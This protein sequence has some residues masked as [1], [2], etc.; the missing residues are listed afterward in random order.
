VGLDDIRTFVIAARRGSLSGAARD[1][2]VPKSTVSR[3]IARLEDELGQELI[4]R[5]SRTFRMTEAGEALFA[6]SAPAIHDLDEATAIVRGAGPEPAGD[7]RITAPVD[8]GSSPAFVRFCV[9]FRDAYPKIKLT[10]DLTDRYVDVVAEGYDLA[11][12]IHARPLES[13]TTLKARK[14]GPLAIGIYASPAYL[15]RRG[16]PTH[17]SELLDHDVIG[18][19]RPEG[20]ER[21]L[22][23]R[24]DE[25][26][27]WFEVRPSLLTSSMPFLPS[28]VEAGAGLGLVADLVMAPL[29]DAGT[30]ERVLPEWEVPP[31]T[32]SLVWPASRVEVP[33]L[34]ALLDFIAADFPKC[35]SEP[36][37]PR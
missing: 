20:G 14:L 9:A 23:R 6:R 19:V 17:P 21:W 15:K 22:L 29:V 25:K 31:A 37:A 2:G 1:L 4:R 11:F 30:V 5:S 32:F 10:V 13:R 7:L 8:V 28:A 27:V 35:G 3:R 16:R 36:T 12:R 34:R 26:P 33:R 18:V 24:N